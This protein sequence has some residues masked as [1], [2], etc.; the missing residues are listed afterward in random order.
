MSLSFC[1][2]CSVSVSNMHAYV[3]LNLQCLVQANYSVVLEASLNS[4]QN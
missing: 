3:D 4:T 2:K 1:L